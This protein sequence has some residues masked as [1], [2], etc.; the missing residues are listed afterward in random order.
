MRQ[1]DVPVGGAR[2]SSTSTESVTEERSVRSS[3]DA[4]ITAAFARGDDGSLHE[5]YIRWSPLIYT[6]ARRSVR[7]DDDAADVTQAV[8][9]A[10][11]QGRQGFDPDSGSLPGW[12]L[13]ITRR[14]IAD[15]YRAAGR[16]PE[17][18]EEL[19]EEAALDP[20]VETVIDK[21]LLADE[22]ERLGEPQRRILELCFYQDM[23]HAQVA[24]LLDLPLGTVKSHV[25]RSL[26]RL[27]DRLEVDGVRR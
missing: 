3:A 4:D 9:V 23:T 25:R 14:K 13:G 20:A 24:S 22:I 12:L 5:V 10:A 8:F 18:R 16:A 19:P 1:T 15:H 27:R 2:A 26:G 6:V 11:W 17:P 7:N 21:V